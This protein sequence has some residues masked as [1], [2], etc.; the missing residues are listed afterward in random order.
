MTV[1]KAPKVD[2]RRYQR[3]FVEQ[4]LNENHHVDEFI[5]AEVR[6]LGRTATSGPMTM[7]PEDTQAVLSYDARWSGDFSTSLTDLSI[8]LRTA[9]TDKRLAEGRYYQPSPHPKSPEYVIHKLVQ[10]LFAQ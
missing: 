10:Q 3:I 9:H 8:A 1:A 4:P 7:M 2:L 6:R 5:A